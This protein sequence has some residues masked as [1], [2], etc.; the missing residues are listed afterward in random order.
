VLETGQDFADPVAAVP[1]LHAGAALLIAMFLWRRVRPRW[2][3]VLALYPV[4]MGFCLVYT[5]EHY[6]VDVL[7]GFAFAVFTALLSSRVERRWCRAD[8]IP[9]TAEPDP[10]R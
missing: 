10:V 6:V 4:F 2:R 1:S 9:A 5:A 7:A 8:R 3:P